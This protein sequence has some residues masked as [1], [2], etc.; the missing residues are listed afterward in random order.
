MGAWV[1]L[2]AGGL[3]QGSC[4]H[5]RR[6]LGRRGGEGGGADADLE[7]EQVGRAGWGE[8][9]AGE[10]ADRA[11]PGRPARA[12]QGALPA[13]GAGPD[14]GKL[15]ADPGLADDLHEP[16]APAGRVVL[17]ASGQ[18]QG[19][20]L[21]MPTVRC[22]VGLPL[23]PGIA[24][25]MACG[26]RLRRPRGFPAR[27]HDSGAVVRKRRTLSGCV[28]SKVRM[29]RGWPLLA[30]PDVAGRRPGAAC[31]AG[32][33]CTTIVGT[34]TQRLSR[35][36]LVDLVGKLMRAEGSAVDLEAWLDL[37]ERNVPCPTGYVSDLIFWPPDGQDLSAEEV[38]DRALA[39]RPIEL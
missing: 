10:L 24:G 7:G 4:G 25:Q 27:Q 38:V 34:M 18:V 26:P 11:A 30:A 13:A 37:I 29:L 32:A 2:L 8:A 19:P 3:G 36:E 9:E 6:E 35:D 12:L 16:G 17:E 20:V 39:Y 14:P 31:R 1:H 15:P 23:S 33:S 5:R 28:N 22:G 21:D